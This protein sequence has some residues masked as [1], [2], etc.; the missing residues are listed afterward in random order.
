[1]RDF[2]RNEGLESAMGLSLF[3]QSAFTI[4]LGMGFS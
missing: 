1:M 4:Y 3:I 2:Q